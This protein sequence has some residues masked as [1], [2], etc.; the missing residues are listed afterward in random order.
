MLS[1]S[2]AR[3]RTR[4]VFKGGV[5]TGRRAARSAELRREHDPDADGPGEQRETGR[6]FERTRAGLTRCEL[7]PAGRK[8]ALPDLDPEIARSSPRAGAERRAIADLAA[9]AW[10]FYGRAAVGERNFVYSPYSIAVASAMLS[11][12]AGRKTLAEIQ[13]ALRF[14]HTGAKLHET[15]N[16][17]SSVLSSRNHPDTRNSDALEYRTKRDTAASPRARRVERWC[18][19]L[20]P[21]ARFS[22]GR[23]DLAKNSLICSTNSL[24]SLDAFGRCE[25]HA[26][27]DV[28]WIASERRVA[29][30]AASD[31]PT[32]ALRLEMGPEALVCRRPEA[33]RS[34]V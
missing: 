9:F 31:L 30:S 19:K 18:A 4:R 20:R 3:L 7:L 1:D 10:D 11:A 34:R 25:P 24:I 5:Q 17:L 33:W 2:A 8:A 32:N 29:A 15:H 21:T 12:A 13:N 26:P 14:S 16:A 27:A 28:S 6:R 22:Q 23:M